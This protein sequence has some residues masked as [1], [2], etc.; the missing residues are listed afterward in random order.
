MTLCLSDEV[1][2]VMLDRAVA[3]ARAGAD[4]LAGSAS[5]FVSPR[6]VKAMFS[7]R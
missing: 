4:Y 2:R 6:D 5:C 3:Y 7:R 1:L